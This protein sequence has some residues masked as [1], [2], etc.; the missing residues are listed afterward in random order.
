MR[1]SPTSKRCPRFSP[2]ESGASRWVA[3]VAR[4]SHRVSPGR[5]W[6]KRWRRPMPGFADDVT[7]V[8]IAGDEE[9]NIARTLGQLGWAKEVIV[10][11]SFSK[12]ATVEIARRFLNVRVVPRAIDT[13]AGQWTFAVAQAR[14]PWVL[15][16]DADYFAPAAFA[17]EIEALTPA[18]NVAG[19]E[20]RFVY[21]I[22][23]KPLRASLY[24]PRTVLL[25]A[26]RCEF[27]MDGHTQ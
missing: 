8:V 6:Q 20:S 10:V 7:P 17:R 18:R 11:D 21:A 14:T 13:L 15:T 23:G 4:S 5:A 22:G 12:D 1:E 3:A 19:Y 25:R 9:A 27:Y 2:T 16:L 26:D 24:P